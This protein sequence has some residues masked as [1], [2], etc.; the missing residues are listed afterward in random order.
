[1]SLRIVLFS[2]ICFEIVGNTLPVL[3]TSEGLHLGDVPPEKYA[4]IPKQACKGSV[5]SI[6]RAPHGGEV[7]QILVRIEAPTLGMLLLLAV[8]LSL[9]TAQILKLFFPPDPYCLALVWIQMQKAV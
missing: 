2:P 3:Q 4:C 8:E 7:H 9:H 6:R 1:M 5:R